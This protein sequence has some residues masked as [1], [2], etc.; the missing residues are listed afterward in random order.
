MVS[1]GLYRATAGCVPAA[2]GHVKSVGDHESRGSRIT[3]K[4]DYVLLPPQLTFLQKDQ[5]EKPGNL[6]SWFREHT[7][8]GRDEYGNC[9]RSS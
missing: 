8:E 1:P 9:L 5:R 4:F 2:T 6:L 7:G 3:T